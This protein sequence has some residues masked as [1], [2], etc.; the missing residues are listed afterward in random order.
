MKI[1]TEFLVKIVEHAP[2]LTVEL[3]RSLN[4]QLRQMSRRVL[5]NRYHTV[6]QRLCMWVLMVSERSGRSSIRITHSDAARG[7]GVHRPTITDA[8][9]ILTEQGLLEQSTGRINIVDQRAIRK[10]ACD[11]IEDLSMAAASGSTGKFVSVT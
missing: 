8:M 10:L 9:A 3:V 7:L 11:C 2:E 1:R 5:C 6:E 4:G